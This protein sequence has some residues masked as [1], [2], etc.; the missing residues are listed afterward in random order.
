MLHGEL[1]KKRPAHGPK[2]CWRNLISTGL[3][4]PNLWTAARNC[5]RTET[6]GTN[7]VKK[8]YSN[9]C[10]L[11]RT[12][13]LPINKLDLSLLAWQS[14]E[15]LE[16]V[17]DI[18]STANQHNPKA[19]TSWASLSQLLA[20]DDLKLDARTRCVCV[21]VCV[22]GDLFLENPLKD[23]LSQLHSYNVYS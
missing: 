5:A 2:K 20:V 13:M 8:A 1:R 23:T 3:W 14:L 18:K 21:C 15:D 12:Q 4:Y 22:Q 19:W 9:F 10:K 6:V 17:Q 7:D 11:E 16:I